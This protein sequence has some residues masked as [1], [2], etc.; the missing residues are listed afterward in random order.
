MFLEELKTKQ[1]H[2]ADSFVEHLKK[3]GCPSTDEEEKVAQLIFD[4][5]NG[6]RILK[7][8]ERLFG[9]VVTHAAREPKV[10]KITYDDDEV[11]PTYVPVLAETIGLSAAYDM[12]FLAQMNYTYRKW[13]Q[14]A[15]Q[16]L[17]DFCEYARKE[18]VEE[19]KTET[20]KA[21]KIRADLAL[22]SVEEK[23]KYGV[24]AEPSL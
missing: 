12:E 16:E 7:E 18:V 8:K 14:I 9:G 15:H 1:Q 21:E 19:I 2:I 6:K 24:K 17:E 5:T 4:D 3:A 22:M 11:M 23:A 10:L 20:L 13:R